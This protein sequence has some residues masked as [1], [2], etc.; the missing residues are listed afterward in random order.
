MKDILII[1]N[2]KIHNANALSSPYTVGFPAMSAWLG[3]MHALERKLQNSEFR[4]IKFSGLV[5]SC[6]DMVLHTHKGSGDY[7]SSIVSTRNPLGRDGKPPAFIEEARCDIEVTIGIECEMGFININDFISFINKVLH[8]MKVASGDLISFK[9]IQHIEV[10]NDEPMK[11]GKYLMPGFCLVS[12]QELMKQSMCDGLDG[13]DA[14]LEYIKISESIQIDES[15]S[16]KRDKS[17]KEKGWIVPISVGYQAISELETTNNQ[18]DSDTPH[19]FVENIV[20]LGE[21]K[22]AYHFDNINEM[23]WRY[24]VDKEK[25][26]YLCKNNFNTKKQE[27][28]L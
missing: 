21:F 14:L 24:E 28:K 23:M 9:K 15:K 17:K 5:I 12:R 3:F 13:I 8:T 4:D 7:V 2:I 18:R 22:M 10:E 27:S 16:I 19:R 6:L 26:L 25:G 20:T 11:L 1:E